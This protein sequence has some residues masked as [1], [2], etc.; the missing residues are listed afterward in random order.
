MRYQSELEYQANHDALTGLPN[1][2]L[3]NDRL[4]RAISSA[5]RNDKLM[6]L[7]FIDLD[8]FKLINDTLGHD[9]G[10]IVLK[11]IARRLTQCLR[12]ADT[13]ARPGGD[14]FLLILVEQE[15]IESISAVIRRILEM[16]A[17]PIQLDLAVQNEVSAPRLADENPP[18]STDTGSDSKE[19]SNLNL[20]VK[21]ERT[22]VI[23]IHGRDCMSP[24]VSE[25][26]FICRMAMTLVPYL[27]MQIRRCTMRKSVV[28]TIFNFLILQ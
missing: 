20:F 6:A 1:R 28:E 5:E 26:V 14:E 2:N 13:A 9:A 4:Q 22:D 27:K 15:S 25:L 10:D 16:I 21:D 3:L 18:D 12:D 17:L 7:A 8:S 19:L 24:A 23:A 11:T